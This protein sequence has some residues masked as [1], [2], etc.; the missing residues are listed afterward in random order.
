M[1][2]VDGAMRWLDG[3]V[4]TRQ[5]SGRVLGRTEERCAKRVSVVALDGRGMHIV[6]RDV[7]PAKVVRRMLVVVI[8]VSQAQ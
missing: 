5:A 2:F 8:V 7:Q 3:V 6:G 4:R 1:V